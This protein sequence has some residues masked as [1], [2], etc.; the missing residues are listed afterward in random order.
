MVIC[1]LLLLTMTPIFFFGLL[2]YRKKRLSDEDSVKS[3]GTLYKGRNV[4]K[5]TN[6]VQFDPLAFFFRRSLF[7]CISVFLFNSPE[8]QMI[9]NQ[10]LIMAYIVYLANDSAKFETRSLAFV[11]I[12]TETLLLLVCII[13]QQLTD[14]RLSSL[15]SDK[16]DVAF[17][18][19]ISCLCL[20]NAS[21]MVY[22]LVLGCK[23]K[24]KKR[25]LLR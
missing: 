17:L 7:T 3:F 5:P 22:L 1:L 10:C 25:Q 4:E 19:S 8:I 21:Y 11:E 16:I 13:L 23:E 24:L 14:P 20:V 18:I 6:N 2:A 15:S 12:G 9:V